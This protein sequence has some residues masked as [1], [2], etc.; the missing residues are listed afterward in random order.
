MLEL[1]HQNLEEK[2]GDRLSL[3]NQVRLRILILN[4]SWNPALEIT[5]SGL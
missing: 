2:R 3:S 5:S 1:E 4:T